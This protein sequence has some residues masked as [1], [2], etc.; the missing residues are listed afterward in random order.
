MDAFAMTSKHPLLG[1][2][3][4]IEDLRLFLENY[5]QWSEHENW[6]A[7]ATT[8]GAGRTGEMLKNLHTFLRE[9]LCNH[10]S[11]M[12][13]WRKVAEEYAKVPT[14]GA[15]EQSSRASNVDSTITEAADAHEAAITLAEFMRGAPRRI[16]GYSASVGAV[17]GP[18]ELFPGAKRQLHHLPGTTGQTR[19]SPRS[20]H[21]R[22]NKGKRKRAGAPVLESSAAPASGTPSAEGNSTPRRPTKP[23]TAQRTTQASPR[24]AGSSCI[25]SPGH[26]SSPGTAHKRA[27]KERLK[28]L[29]AANAAQEAP[30]ASRAAAGSFANFTLNPLAQRWCVCEFFYSSTDDA[31]LRSDELNFAREMQRKFPKISQIEELTKY[32]WFR[33]KRA[34]GKPRRFSAAFARVQ[35]QQLHHNRHIMRQLQFGVQP[36]CSRATIP[37]GI[38]APL[39][40][41]QRVMARPRVHVAPAVR[42][43]HGRKRASGPGGG[44]EHVSNDAPSNAAEAR[45]S[46]RRALT[47]GCYPGFV[48]AV[49]S[50]SHAYMV[51]FDDAIR[52][53]RQ[54]VDDTDIMPCA[55]NYPVVQLERLQK[56]RVMIPSAG[57]DTFRNQ[58]PTAST[59]T[60]SPLRQR[61]A[62]LLQ[63]P[64]GSAPSTP[65]RRLIDAAA[66]TSPL[67]ART[68]TPGSTACTDNGTGVVAERAPVSTRECIQDVL[69]AVQSAV[70]SARALRQQQRQGVGGGSASAATDAIEVAA[71]RALLVKQHLLRAYADGN[72]R[73]QRWATTGDGGSGHALRCQG[74]FVRHYLDRLNALLYA[75]VAELSV[76]TSAQPPSPAPVAPAKGAGQRLSAAAET[77]WATC[78]ARAAELVRDC[79][80]APTPAQ[81]ATLATALATALLA[82][83]ESGDVGHRDAHGLLARAAASLL[84]IT[85]PHTPSAGVAHELP[86]LMQDLQMQLV[87]LLT[88]VCSPPDTSSLMPASHT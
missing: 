9:D 4:S 20:A 77:V 82:V 21:V 62:S 46:R 79:A 8:F 63:S 87:A 10:P 6:N 74:R 60:G 57:V 48:L 66:A 65:K 67:G 27:R 81:H 19:V 31:L 24:A 41:G 78:T 54:V 30:S 86:T 13:L 14:I 51:E 40:L 84:A 56:S 73:R 7:W 2:P 50:T 43:R 53:G 70:T 88:S 22:G 25:A 17:G 32:E 68:E 33:V 58:S 26:Q 36:D 64:L 55:Q 80:T 75:A 37:A 59:P 39:S 29:R 23:D 45:R 34:L 72:A 85:G 18:R 47:V 76:W 49:M 69:H 5:S 35:R 44:G 83:R 16:Q 61:S 71:A 52:F 28:L 12:D 3:Y 1:P 42:R 38:P 15:D 11:A